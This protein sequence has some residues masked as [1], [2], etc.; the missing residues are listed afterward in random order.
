[1]LY[2]RKFTRGGKKNKRVVEGWYCKLGGV[3]CK[4]IVG[5]LTI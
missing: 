2:L 4:K 1:M 3:E 5:K